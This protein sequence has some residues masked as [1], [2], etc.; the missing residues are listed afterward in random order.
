MGT[1]AATGPPTEASGNFLVSPNVGLMIWTLIAFCI[2]LLVLQQ[3]AF[4][5]IGEALD[6]R[7]KAIE[8]SID[9]AERTRQEA[10]QLLEEYRA[11][12]QRGA[13][14]GRRHRRP[15]AQGGGAPRRT[16]S[17]RPSSSARS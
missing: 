17:S 9:A 3:H 4:P 12:L 15:R 5:A 13:R 11:R 16:R 2:T 14:A 10:D 7:Q 6:K 8:E 1:L